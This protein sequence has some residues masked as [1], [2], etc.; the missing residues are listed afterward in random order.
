MPLFFDSPVSL[1]WCQSW[2]LCGNADANVRGRGHGGVLLHG[3][4]G[5]F[6]PELPLPPSAV[7]EEEADERKEGERRQTEL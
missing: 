4:A 2:L 6:N 7:T 5:L 1:F 3:R